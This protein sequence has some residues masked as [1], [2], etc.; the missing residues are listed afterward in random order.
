MSF[1]IP[2][3]CQCLFTRMVEVIWED[4]VFNMLSGYHEL[5][6]GG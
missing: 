1:K 4:V 2:P 5:Y 3:D 6:L